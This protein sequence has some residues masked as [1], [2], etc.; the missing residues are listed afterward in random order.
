MLVV[1]NFAFVHPVFLQW[2]AAF[3]AIARLKE[4]VPSQWRRR[5]SNIFQLVGGK[6]LLGLQLDYHGL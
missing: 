6:L 4:G 2:L 1:V 5:V 3:K